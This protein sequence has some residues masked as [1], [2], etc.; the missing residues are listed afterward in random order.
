MDILKTP[1]QDA[2]QAKLAAAV[3]NI[4]HVLEHKQ[5]RDQRTQEELNLQGEI[6]MLLSL[7]EDK[8]A[9]TVKRKL[10]ALYRTGITEPTTT[11]PATPVAEPAAPRTLA[12]DV[13][14]M[15]DPMLNG[16]RGAGAAAETSVLDVCGSYD[17]R[18]MAA[19]TGLEALALRRRLSCTSVA[20]TTLRWTPVKTGLEALA[21]RRRL[22][23]T[24]AAPTTLRWMSVEV[25]A[26]P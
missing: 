21:P 11:T 1:Q 7:G 18:W 4:S 19:K 8:E 23:W 9:A 6:D 26:F 25:M 3:E 14:G 10:L 12:V 5:A 17:L 13:S 2:H 20:P 22:P 24:S 16:A 15:K